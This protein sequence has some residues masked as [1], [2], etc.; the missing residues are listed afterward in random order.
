LTGCFHLL[1]GF[2]TYLVTTSLPP[3]VAQTLVRDS[4]NTLAMDRYAHL[5][6]IDLVEPLKPLPVIT[7]VGNTPEYGQAANTT[8]AR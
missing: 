6:V 7:A 1:Q 3:K 4:T 5:G 8:A 2:I